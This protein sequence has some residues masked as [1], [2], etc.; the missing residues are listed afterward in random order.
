MTNPANRN[1]RR[2]PLRRR[3]A[4]KAASDL[5]L[6]AAREERRRMTGGCCEGDTPACRPGVHRGVLAHHIRRRKGQV[7]VHDVEGLRW[8][9][10]PG[11]DWVHAHPLEARHLGLLA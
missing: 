2:K 8:L 9:C 6:A 3:S 7:G 10:R 1:P 4:K 5:V 11:H